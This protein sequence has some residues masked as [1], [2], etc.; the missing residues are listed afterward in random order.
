[1][2]KSVTI[3]S[4]EGAMTILLVVLVK[5]NGAI[6]NGRHYGQPSVYET[7][8]G[9]LLQ[10]KSRAGSRSPPRPPPRSLRLRLCRRPGAAEPGRTVGEDVA[11]IAARF[12]LDAAALR[13]VVEE[14][15]D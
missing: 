13:R 1:L 14:G 4:I 15:A 2:Y 3:V 9:M 12:G 6:R 11:D 5:G 8:P 7:I 10:A